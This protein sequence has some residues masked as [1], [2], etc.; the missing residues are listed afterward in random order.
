MHGSLEI[1]Q[2]LRL[3]I[4]LDEVRPVKLA[5]LPRAPATPVHNVARPDILQ[6]NLSLATMRGSCLIGGHESAVAVA[7]Q[8]CTERPKVILKGPEPCALSRRL[9]L[10]ILIYHHESGSCDLPL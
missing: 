3:I 6:Q 4:W 1:G 9:T 10:C 7:Y 2:I 8:N 5:G